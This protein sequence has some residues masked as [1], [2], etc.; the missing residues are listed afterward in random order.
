MAPR[1][2]ARWPKR[3]TY[4]AL[5]EAKRTVSREGVG[6]PWK[7]REALRSPQHAHGRVPKADLTVGGRQVFNRMCELSLRRACLLPDPPEPG[8]LTFCIPSNGEHGA[9]QRSASA[10]KAM[11]KAERAG[12]SGGRWRRQRRHRPGARSSHH[13]RAGAAGRWACRE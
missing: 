12:V 1:G 9:R 2:A 4:D 13:Q 8:S 10:G 11:R 5:Q 3:R 6:G 7:D